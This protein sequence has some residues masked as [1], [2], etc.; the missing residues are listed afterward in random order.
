MAKRE[1]RTTLWEPFAGSASVGLKAIGVRYSICTYMG[2]KL[3]LAKHILG[4]LGVERDAIEM[5]VLTDSGPWGDVWT[6][7][8]EDLECI[9]DTLTDFKAWE[10]KTLYMYLRNCPPQENVSIR[11]ARFLI[12][13][14]LN[15][16][17]KPVGEKTDGSGYVMHGLDKTRAY[18]TTK[19]EKFGEVKP[20]W[21]K[22]PERLR[23]I[24]TALRDGGVKLT[25][26]R[27]DAMAYL[28]QCPKDMSRWVVYMDPP[29]EGTTQGYGGTFSRAEVAFLAERCRARGAKVAISYNSGFSEFPCAVYHCLTTAKKASR[30]NKAGRG[31]GIK[32]RQEWLTV[33]GK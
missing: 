21:V 1:N 10:P 25:G 28:E 16:K 5:L 2:G 19:T 14:A 8:G 26:G 15:F 12:L 3:Q 27:F 32:A 23:A 4:A 13:Q 29:Y 31:N 11:A 20:Q 9:I 17:G 18:G 30:M 6:H 24:E 7:A 22:L 33:I